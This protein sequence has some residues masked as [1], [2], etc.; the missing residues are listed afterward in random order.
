MIQ[1]INLI[2]N[3]GGDQES[4]GISSDDVFYPFVETDEFGIDDHLGHG[5]HTAGTAAGSPFSSPAEVVE[6]ESGKVT[7]CGGGCISSDGLATDDDADD[8]GIDRLCPMFDCY[9][10]DE[11]QQCLDD[12]VSE[13]LSEHGGM[14][15][16]AK[17]SMFD[18]FKGDYSYGDLAGNGLWEACLDAGC[19]IHSNSYGADKRCELSPLD[20]VYDDFMYQVPVPCSATSTIPKWVREE[21]VQLLPLL[22][23]CWHECSLPSLLPTP[24]P[25]EPLGIESEGAHC[26]LVG[27]RNLD[28]CMQLSTSC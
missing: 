16:G 3:D 12:D 24:F 19:K 7:G 26:L 17:L 10:A 9:P 23:G 14:A 21:F 25:P 4:E 22:K 18:I 13:T 2:K 8:E 1:Y 28:F 15:Q 20:I 5:S 11:E 27:H 6:C